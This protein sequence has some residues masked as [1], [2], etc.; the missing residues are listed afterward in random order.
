M[1]LEGG[2]KETKQSEHPSLMDEAQILE[3]LQSDQP[4]SGTAPDVQSV[5]K[6]GDY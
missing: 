5:L 4:A 2:M 6:Y 1:Q 3:I